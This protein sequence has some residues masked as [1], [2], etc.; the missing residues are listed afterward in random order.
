LNPRAT[1]RAPFL[2]GS[3]ERHELII[4]FKRE[5]PS[6]DLVEPFLDLDDIERVDTTL[7]EQLSNLSIRKVE[8]KFV[9]AEPVIGCMHCGSEP[10]F[11]SSSA[12]HE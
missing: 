4:E 5:E 7:L 11:P 12:D 3:L 6:S 10:A 8:L 1:M 2:T 9:R